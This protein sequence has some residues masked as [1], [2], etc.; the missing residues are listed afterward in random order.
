M[1][2]ILFDANFYILVLELKRELHAIRSVR[3]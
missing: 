1:I 2:I 3:S